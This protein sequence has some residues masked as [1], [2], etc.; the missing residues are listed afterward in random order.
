M[1]MNRAYSLLTVKAI[2]DDKRIIT[3]I[4]TTPTADRAGDVVEPEG[5]DFELPIPLLW[6]HDSRQ[7][8]GHVTQ[9]KVTSAGIEIT[10]Q[11]ASSDEPGILKD[12]LDYAWQCMKKGLVRGLSIGFKE[13]ESARIEQTYSY[14]YLKWLWLEL[15]AVTIPAN[16]EATIQ[17][18]KSI[19]TKQRAAT[20]RK[21]LSVV[22]LDPPGASG[23]IKTSPK[24]KPKEG[25][26]M[27]TLAEQITALETKRAANVARQQTVMQKSID[28]GR[29]TDAAEQEDFDTLDQEVDAID[30]DLTR[31]RKLEKTMAATAKPIVNVDDDAAGS[32]A[33]GGNHH[34]RVDVKSAPKLAPGIGFAQLVKVKALSRMLNIPVAEVAEKHYGEN[35]A[36]AGVFKTAVVAGSSVSGNWAYDLVSQEGGV[37]A[38]F[39]E[40]LRPATILGKFGTNGIPSLNEVPF[41]TPLII[42]T[43]G[44][45]GYWVGQGKAKPLTA[46]DFDRTT[47]D[48]LK[49]ANICVLTEE[50]IRASSP[51]SDV[52]VRNSLRDALLA[53]LDTDFVDPAK[54]ASAGVSPASITNGAAAIASTGTDADH[55][56]LDIRALYQKFIDA[57]NAPENGVFIMSTSNALA[58]S[59]MVNAL[60]QK[61]FPT[62]TMMG[63][64]FEGLPVIASRYV[65]TNVV[66]LNASDVYQA[67][68]GGVQVDMSREASLEMSDAPAQ[69]A[70][71]GTGAS[72]VS[73]FQTNSV[74]IRAERIINW[75][76]RR[77]AGVAYLTGVAW[78]GAV[79]AS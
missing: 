79:P 6:Q 34:P 61:E 43:G 55:V 12:A 21:P 30:K 18:V 49:V 29:S 77:A 63:G 33:R 65:G 60:G 46:M 4:A 40:F 13:I 45:A 73:M 7:P 2:D 19:D 26:D 17:T 35:S 36:I 27:K 58:A 47:I 39:A 74:A 54:T 9:A 16:G 11:I 25:T 76:R 52:I 57:D 50:S 72:M 1:N 31:L 59:M 69:T 75:K 51:K 42:Q 41:R 78:G 28:E 15:S 8:I 14:R 70:L 3:G 32:A 22:R 48:E 66:L 71:V 67:D 5:A 23:K 53:R 62:I 20:G 24:L 68:E 44:G 38:D 56:R 10:A 37:A 64:V